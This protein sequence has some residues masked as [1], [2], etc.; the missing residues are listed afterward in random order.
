MAKLRGGGRTPEMVEALRVV[1]V[2]G[3]RESVRLAEV[4]QVVPRGRALVVMVGEKEVCLLSSSL[5][6]S[7]LEQLLR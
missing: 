4:A 3:S 2:K 5:L 6:D 7:Y 1:L